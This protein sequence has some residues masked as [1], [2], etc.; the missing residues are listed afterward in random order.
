MSIN[1]EVYHFNMD[2]TISDRID[3]IK[4]KKILLILLILSKMIL[5]LSTCQ[6]IISVNFRGI[7]AQ[8]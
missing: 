1:S 5:V 7:E 2:K 3:R 8:T 4:G 6:V